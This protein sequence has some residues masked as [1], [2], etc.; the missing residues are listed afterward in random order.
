M[1]ES[2][3]E[4]IVSAHYSRRE[5]QEEIARF[6]QCRWVAVHCETL[7]QQGFPVWLRYQRG[8]GATKAP[9]AIEEADD[10]LRL[11]ER[12]RRLKPRTFYASICVYKELSKQ[13]S[14]KDLHNIVSCSPVW[15]IDSTQEKWK[16]TIE[17]AKEIMRLLREEGLSRSVFLKWSGNGAHVHVHQKAFSASLLRRIS[18][19]DGS[20][21]V[22][23]YVNRVLRPRL[24][25]VKLKHEAL[26][27]TVENEIDVQRVFTCPLSLHRS[28]NCVA[29]CVS[30][31]SIDDFTL[32]WT[33]VSDFRHWKEWDHYEE[34]EGDSLAE[35]A[36]HSAGGYEMKPPP[37]PKAKEATHPITK[38][39][40]PE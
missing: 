17:V 19:L 36:Y 18:P 35:I 31:A 23:E 30:P 16:A 2:D 7:N 10:V 13:D 38:W 24:A 15:D 20:Y 5:V 6:S 12:H 32:D 26:E 27:L 39:F 1:S 29:V 28:L 33:R 40:G 4:R 25:E 9:L 8:A 21:A 3:Y 11:L 37:K 14:L 34:G 22:V